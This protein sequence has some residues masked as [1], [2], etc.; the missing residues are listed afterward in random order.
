MKKCV[1]SGVSATPGKDRLWD[2]ID[3][4]SAES[5]LDELMHF[6]TDD[7]AKEIWESITGYSFDS[8]NEDY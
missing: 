7:Q 2:L 5:V 3:N 6:I 4:G 1:K 8:D